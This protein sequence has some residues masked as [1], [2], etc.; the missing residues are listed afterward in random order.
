MIVVVFSTIQF[1]GRVFGIAWRETATRLMLRVRYSGG[2]TATRAIDNC[3]LSGL[4]ADAGIYNPRFAIELPNLWT[5]FDLIGKPVTVAETYSAA[6]VHFC[7]S[8]LLRKCEDR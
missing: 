7:S 3:T 8:C 5:A 6:D 2:V 1:E 4:L